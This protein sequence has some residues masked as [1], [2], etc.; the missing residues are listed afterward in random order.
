MTISIDFLEGLPGAD[1]VSKGLSDLADAK[2]TA[3]AALVEIARER[4]VELG[5]AVEGRTIGEEDAE[6]VLYARLCERH[7]EDDP[8][9]L[10]NAW[11]DQLVSFLSALGNRRRSLALRD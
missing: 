11:L 5:L 8:Y 1:L 10:Y 2:S 7:P 4:L 6:I 9:G 3:E